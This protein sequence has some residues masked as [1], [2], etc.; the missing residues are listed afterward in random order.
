MDPGNWATDLAGRKQVWLYIDM[1]I[2]DEQPDGFIATKP[3]CKTG[4]SKRK[5]PGTGQPGNI[6]E[7]H[8]LYFI[9]SGRNCYCSY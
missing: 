2:A 8:K 3:I 1:G 4:N 7:V 5:G 6:S 9:C